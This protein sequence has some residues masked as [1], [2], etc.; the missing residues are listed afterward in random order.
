MSFLLSAA[1][2][3]FFST[4]HCLGMC[5]P[6]VLAL[7]LHERRTSLSVAYRVLYNLGRIFTYAL[8]GAVVGGAGFLFSLRGYQARVAYAAGVLLI[9]FSLVQLM[10]FMHWTFFSALHAR[11]ARLLGR[12]TGNAGPGRFFLLGFVNGFL[13]CGMVT[14]ALAAS[15]ALGA[16]WGGALFMV[17][18]GLGTFPVM[19][20]ASLFGMY[21][22]PR[23]KRSLALA[24][25][26]FSLALG[27]LLIW[28]P[29][30]LVPH[31]H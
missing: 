16:V 13:P 21:L 11:I 14:A 10:P 8:L 29:A 28:R 20:A 6:L 3:G 24:G 25:P 12:F 5:G 2:L 23:L 22:T 4:G 31:C 1:A 18:F 15:L 7:P 17:F 19:L 26:L 9:L 30:L 27:I